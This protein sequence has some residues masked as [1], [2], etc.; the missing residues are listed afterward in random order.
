M[1]ICTR[2]RSSTV[3]NACGES[4]GLDRRS[5]R[6]RGAGASSIQSER[7]VVDIVELL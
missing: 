1:S 7:E 4:E 5:A 2:G 6:G 3:G